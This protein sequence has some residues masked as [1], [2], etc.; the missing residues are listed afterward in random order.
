MAAQALSTKEI[1][2]KVQLIA[3]PLYFFVTTCLDK[4]GGIAALHKAIDVRASLWAS[5]LDGDSLMYAHTH[6][7]APVPHR[8]RR[9]RAPSSPSTGATWW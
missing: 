7:L 6:T 2:I 5:E 9:R 8:L 1:A 4:E 3:P